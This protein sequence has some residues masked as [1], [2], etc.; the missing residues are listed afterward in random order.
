MQRL[1]VGSI[2]IYAQTRTIRTY[3]LSYFSS[4][5]NHLSSKLHPKLC[6]TRVA[7]NNNFS[8]IQTSGYSYSRV[9][10]IQID[11]HHT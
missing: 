1:R 6:Q 3:L 2:S 8:N 4:R 9:T 10:V 11:V 5:L 7:Y